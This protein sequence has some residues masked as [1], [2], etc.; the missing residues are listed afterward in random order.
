MA[1]LLRQC[2]WRISVSIGL[3]RHYIETWR[4]W[5]GKREERSRQ[6]YQR[7]EAQFL[8][9]VLALQE[10]PFSPTL[11]WTSRVLICFALGIVIWSFVSKVDVIVT[12]QGKVVPGD[13]IKTIASVETASV[14][15]L[16]VAEGESVRAGQLLVELDAT[17][18][19]TEYDKAQADA[20]SA[21]IDK[22]RAKALIRAIDTGERPV[23]P[24]LADFE[25]GGTHVSQN[26]VDAEKA[27]LWGAYAD[28]VAK[29]EQFRAEI[30]RYETTLPLIEKTAKDYGVML[31]NG[32][33]S[34]HAFLEKEE[35]RI[36]LEGL[37]RDAKAKLG[38]LATETKR[39][40]Y[41]LIA[42]S[43]Q[44]EIAAREDQRRSAQ[45]SHLL[46][47]TAPV[48]GVVQ[49]LTLHTIG[50][51]VPPA[52]PLMLIVPK[53]KNVEIEAMLDN[54]DVGFV[55]EGQEA[56]V[57]I[58]TFDYTKFGTL[59]ARVVHVSADAIPQDQ[60]GLQ[61]A[62]RIVLD[63]S[64]MMVDNRK[65][66]V[67]PGMTVNVDI[68]LGERRVMDYLLTPLLQHTGGSFHE[69]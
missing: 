66:S 22:A 5:W 55:Q 49:Q 20:A 1:N 58:D 9:G 16:H 64:E 43:E 46:K 53:E 59:G 33:V 10:T 51:V 30:A 25:L 37:L 39:Q 65:V 8:P 18:S 31:G 45:H 27:H 67:T 47:L 42:T 54:K 13:R 19:D 41:D 2:A 14:V 62:A 12:A 69:R 63:R 35:A 21:M 50:G 56:Q 60:K 4:F 26:N 29:A 36:E 15:A 17:A 7:D 57:K 68:K 44:R 34:Q 52:Q 6:P 28:Y 38:G 61:Y 3:A 11:V 32:D 40:A 23:W 48:D 24:R